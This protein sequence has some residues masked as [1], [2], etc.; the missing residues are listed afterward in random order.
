MKFS[1]VS[2]NPHLCQA[3]FKNGLISDD[4]LVFID[5]GLRKNH[6]LKHENPLDNL[7]FLLE[8]YSLSPMF[9]TSGGHFGRML[10]SSYPSGLSGLVGEGEL[11]E[12]VVNGW[13][14]SGN[15]HNLSSVFGLMVGCPDTA[16]KIL[17]AIRDN[18]ARQGYKDAVNKEYRT[19]QS[20]NLLADDE[21][22]DYQAKYDVYYNP[23]KCGFYVARPNVTKNLRDK[24][25]YYLSASE[26]RWMKY[27]FEGSE[28]IGP[29]NEVDYAELIDAKMADILRPL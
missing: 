24:A 8:N 13:K 27:A 10:V 19:P 9:E 14:F 12:K 11:L 16:R 4:G 18:Y 28:L 20:F 3:W 25:H 15:F 26:V 17:E 21:P 23:N 2:E 1:P 22:S 7:F 5:S 29:R 6:W